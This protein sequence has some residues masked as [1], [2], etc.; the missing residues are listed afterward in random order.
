MI[1]RGEKMLKFSKEE[2]KSYIESR[3]PYTT[4]INAKKVGNTIAV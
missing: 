2:M 4:I 3:L 1:I